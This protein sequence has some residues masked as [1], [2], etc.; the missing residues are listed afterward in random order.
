MKGD[1][2]RYR[3]EPLVLLAP[4]VVVHSPR[5]WRGRHL[6]TDFGKIIMGRTAA[7][8]TDTEPTPAA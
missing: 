5:L 2:R 3:F 8:P 1:G 4:A 6:V 7:K